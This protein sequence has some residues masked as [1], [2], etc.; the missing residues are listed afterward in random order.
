MIYSVVVK[1]A[2]APIDLAHKIAEAH[3]EAVKSAQ[4]RRRRLAK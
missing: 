2:P 4:R 3:A 1:G